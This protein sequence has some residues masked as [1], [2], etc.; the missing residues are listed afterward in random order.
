MDP[1]PSLLRDIDTERI[2]DDLFY[3]AGE[4]P[5][6]T[7][8]VVRW[9]QRQCT[10]YEADAHIQS[11]LES[12]GYVVRREAVAVQAF[13]RDV[14]KP[15]AHQYS[16]PDPADP[17]Y[18]AYNLYATLRGNEQP[19]EVIVVLAHK[20][21]QSWF[22]PSPGAY[23]NAVGTAATIEIARVLADY[24]PRRSIWFLF[25]NEEHT[26]WT[27]VVAAQALAASD[28][29]VVA[30]I[31]LDGLGAKPAD[32]AGRMTNWTRYTAPEGKPLA[33][34][35]ATLNERYAL[36]LEQH[37]YAAR[38]PDDDDGS[39]ILAGIPQAVLNVGSLPYG[40]PHYHTPKD[41][42]DN[43]DLANVRLA[44][45]LSLAAVVH[46]DQYGL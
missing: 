10:L 22:Y 35:M 43:V 20:D 7:L 25:C 46:L 45:Q 30:A 39:F 38:R 4:L 6:R 3:L 2:K 11:R 41:R 21:S 5:C 27:S 34:L 19:D 15:L 17:W 42:P 26:P 36:G 37:S 31:N 9:G 16:P 14:H 29:R 12:W 13:R 32:L 1:I 28:L 8:N 18:E 40:D 44:T 24:A 33:D 23:D